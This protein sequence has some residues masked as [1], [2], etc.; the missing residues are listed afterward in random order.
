[1]QGDIIINSPHLV[2]DSLP[3]YSC[4]PVR[5]CDCLIKC[6][7]GGSCDAKTSCPQDVRP[8][9]DSAILVKVGGSVEVPKTC[10]TNADCNNPFTDGSANMFCSGSPSALGKCMCSGK[11]TVTSLE[12]YLAERLHNTFVP[13]ETCSPTL[14]DPSGGC[15]GNPVRTDTSLFCTDNNGKCFCSTTA[16]PQSD[17]NDDLIN[18]FDKYDLKIFSEMEKCF[19]EMFLF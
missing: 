5:H 18:G 11:S 12:E 3:A 13:P 19:L 6:A 4:K 10:V 7:A 14:T 1:M 15:N 8:G 9:G 17:K 2:I 16:N